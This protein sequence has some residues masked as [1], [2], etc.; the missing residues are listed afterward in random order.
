MNLSKCISSLKMQLGLY[1]IGLP[2]KDD[3][4][5]EAIPTENV[6]RDVITT[7]TI[8]EYSEFVPWKRIGDCQLDRLKV[9]D[10]KHYIYELP[11]FLTITPVKYIINV[12]LPFHNSRGTYGDIAPAYGI[13]RSV[14]G[15]V[16]SQAYMMV[17]GQMRN[18]PSFEYLGHNQIRLYGYPKTMLTF[19]LACEHDPS[20]ETIED[21]CYDS[22]MELATLDTKVFLYNNLK[23]FDEM[24]SAF[25]AIK[26][27]IENYQDAEGQRDQLLE[28]WRD[29]Y[30]LDMGW[31]T[32]M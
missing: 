3:M 32:W 7:T 29:T 5:G 22:F 23:Y 27:K 14:Q 20:G 11:P 16:T 25:G 30:H 26:L 21:S 31:E 6:I 19:E 10:H 2:F 28:K 8:P 24:P 13:N 12:G 17:A 9:I 1:G 4:S 18:E 15:V